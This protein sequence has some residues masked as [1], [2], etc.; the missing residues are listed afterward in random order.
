MTALSQS[1]FLHALG[2]AVLNSLWQMALLWIL[3]QLITGIFRE[4]KSSQ[5]STLA[6]VLLFGGFGWFV[7]SF[8][9]ILS[10]PLQSSILSGQLPLSNMEQFN[11]WIYQ[12]LPAAA[13]A[14][15]LLLWIPV[16]QFRKNFRYARQIRK[17]GLSKIGVE[18]RLFTAQTASLIG[19]KKK[20]QVWLSA[21]VH[22]PVTVGFL[23][24]MILIPVAAIN[25]L[26]PQQLEA[27]LLH[28]L[29]HIR[30]ND[31]LINLLMHA[32]QALLYFNPFA[33]LFVNT[34]EREREKSCDEMVIHFNCNPH[35]YAT[36]LLILEQSHQARRPFAV[37]ASGN[38]H[39]L[40][41]R[42][43]RILG[44]R[45]KYVFSVR[46]LAAIFT[47]ILF[48]TAFNS[49]VLL[50]KNN[51]A[52][53][54]PAPITHFSGLF[55]FHIN[56]VT[57]LSDF[58]PVTPAMLPIAESKPAAG[59]N[60]GYKKPGTTEI[61]REMVNNNIRYSEPVA[62]FVTGI[63]PEIPALLPDEEKEVQKV[64]EASRMILENAQWKTI[65]G[66]MADAFTSREIEK[67]RP[68]IH[69]QI[70]AEINWKE[71]E[72]RLKTSYHTLNW[73]RLNQDLRA[74]V[75]DIRL[76]SLHQ[77]CL[78]FKQDLDYQINM[79]K[80]THQTAIPDSD[81]TL[82]KLE[83]DKKQIEEFLKTAEQLRKRKIIRL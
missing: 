16:L 28:E 82:H 11:E 47:G 3:Y 69:A 22:S 46:K 57:S 35:L 54:A 29:A 34:I 53:S 39:D 2:W 63:A 64:L 20:V 77:L 8:V 21:L 5:K 32:V 45:R 48:I 33:R 25:N 17:Q 70:N 76:D 6:S 31:Y 66:A 73:E 78:N 42:I 75:A 4:M 44:I 13:I 72:N 79:L 58:S 1:A 36:A 26:S 12:C 18:W 9:V 52:V 37:S 15:I 65:T 59:I 38:R 40:L 81:I 55:Y 30:R 27:L 24:P 68:I 10:N 71:W 61:N 83:N 43:E 14:Y 7:Y 56:S 74:A 49:I 41:H 23:K 50:Q 62:T 60:H 51:Q 80:T 19:I 67:L